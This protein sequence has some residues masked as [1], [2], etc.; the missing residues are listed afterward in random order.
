MFELEN[1]LYLVDGRQQ[2][3]QKSP[4]YSIE[5][6]SRILLRIAYCVLS[7]KPDGRTFSYPKKKQTKE[8]FLLYIWHIYG[9]IICTRTRLIDINLYGLFDLI[10][11]L[12]LS[13]L[14]SNGLLTNLY[15]DKEF[16]K[17]A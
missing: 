8:D 1:C 16:S 14:I 6:R 9:G 17:L 4:T 10:I 13:S 5:I 2:T 11:K 15:L 12:K 7:L 3:F